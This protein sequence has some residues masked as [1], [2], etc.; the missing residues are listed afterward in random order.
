[1]MNNPGQLRHKLT[2]QHLAV[3]PDDKCEQIETWTDLIT[4]HCAVSQF[5]G[6]EKVQA[7]QEITES[8][9]TFTVR[10]SHTLA[11]LNEEDYRIVFKGEIYDI[12][13]INDPQL[14]HEKLI[15]SAKKEVQSELS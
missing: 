6:T 4:V 3:S 14:A 7:R 1:M 12:L 5:T 9:V 15:I 11:T 2:I 8:D 10:Y 13:F